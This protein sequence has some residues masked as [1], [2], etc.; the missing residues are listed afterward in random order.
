MGNAISNTKIFNCE[1]NGQNVRIFTFGHANPLYIN[2]EMLD[3]TDTQIETMI[4]FA[5]QLETSFSSE[6]QAAEAGRRQDMVTA[7]NKILE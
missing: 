3:L 5:A 4:A 7:L 1:I 2:G 6:I